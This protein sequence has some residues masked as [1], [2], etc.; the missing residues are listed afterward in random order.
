MIFPYLYTDM[1]FKHA[2]ILSILSV[3]T[4]LLHAATV[5]ADAPADTIRFDDGSWYTGGIADSLFNGYGK[6]VYADS[7]IYEG[8]WRD[9][10]WNGKAY[11]G[12]ADE[13][14]EM[15]AMLMVSY[16]RDSRHDEK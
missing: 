1:S 16:R 6:M 2:V 8:D 11:V 3:C 4:T 13:H 10:M 15:N 14:G 9:G 5:I 7:T 12:I